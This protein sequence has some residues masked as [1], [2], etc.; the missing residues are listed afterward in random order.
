MYFLKQVAKDDI[1]DAGFTPSAV[2]A[3]LTSTIS[4]FHTSLLVAME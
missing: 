1:G 2:G 4:R 3:D